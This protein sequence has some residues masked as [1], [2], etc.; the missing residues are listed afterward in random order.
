MK[1]IS[2]HAELANAVN[3]VLTYNWADEKDDYLS[4]PEDS[5][6]HIFQTLLSLDQYFNPYEEKMR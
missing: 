1:K 6:N 2:S 5:E 4:H 3:K